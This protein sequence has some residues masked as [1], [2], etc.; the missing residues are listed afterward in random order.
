MLLHPIRRSAILESEL[1]IDHVRALAPPRFEWGLD[2][3]Y[4]YNL[5]SRALVAQWIEQQ[6]ADL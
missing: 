1:A 3:Y 2:A 5:N 4:R 6:V